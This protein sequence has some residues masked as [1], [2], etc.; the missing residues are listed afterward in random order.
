[1]QPRVILTEPEAIIRAALMDLGVGL[2]GVPHVLP[3]LR[4]G[5]LKRVLPDSHADAGPISLY[6]PALKLMPAR[7]RATRTR[8]RGASSA[9]IV[10][11]YFPCALASNFE[12]ASMAL[13]IWRKAAS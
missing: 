9:A 5:D 1:M 2:V 4:S 6:F 8:S 10:G 13:P 12:S 3:H 11:P 7:N